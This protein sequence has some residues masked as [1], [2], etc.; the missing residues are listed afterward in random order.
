[1]RAVPRDD[2]GSSPVKALRQ[3]AA[4]DEITFVA[5]P[6]GTRLLGPRTVS[7]EPPRCGSSSDS[8]A[9]P[10][11]NFLADGAYETVTER[12]A[13]RVLCLHKTGDR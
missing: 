10:R 6:G 2:Q 4:F 1:M 5:H 9:R 3:S 8:T 13:S 11:A 7:E 12:R